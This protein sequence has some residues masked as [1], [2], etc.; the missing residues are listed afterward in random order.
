V[1]TTPF[2]H[3]FLIGKPD[4]PVKLTVAIN[5]YCGPCKNE[6]EKAKELLSIYPGQ[7]SLSLRFLRSGEGG[8]TSG[9]LLKN[10]L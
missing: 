8:E 9:L 1:D 10:W 6:L 2:E 4:A 3:D 7:V 5:L